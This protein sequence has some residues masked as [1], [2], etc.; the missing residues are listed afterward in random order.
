MD[1]VLENE[2]LEIFKAEIVALIQQDSKYISISPDQLDAI[3]KAFDF[4]LKNGREKVRAQML[5][6]LVQEKRGN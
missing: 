5:Y 4:T 1:T 3:V 6:D 2:T